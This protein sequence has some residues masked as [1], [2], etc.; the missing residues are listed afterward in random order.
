MVRNTSLNKSDA[1]IHLRLATPKDIPALESL[2]NESVRA[3]SIG[4]YTPSQ[5]ENALTYV[6]GVDTQLI[7]DKTYFVVEVSGSLA[8]GGGWSKR[9]TLFGGDQAK[10]TE[11]D[12][13]L[14]PGKDAARLRAFYVH[15]AWSR[16]GIGRLITQACETAA[17][18]AGFTR[19]ELIATLPGQPLYEANGYRVVCPFEIPL[20]DN[21]S[22]PAF[23][24][25]KT[26]SAQ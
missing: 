4:Y 13:L 22:L 16:R 6:F 8:G 1:A 17:R 5:I 10:A 7:A 24:M 21:L 15:P 3:L 23:R 18:E 2:I 11:A 14:I 20:P 25:T 19:L 12:A 9:K 26:L